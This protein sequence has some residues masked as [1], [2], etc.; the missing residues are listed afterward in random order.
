MVAVLTAIWAVVAIIVTVIVKVTSM[1]GKTLRTICLMIAIAVQG[2]HEVAICNFFG[3]GGFR[4][5]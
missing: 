4:A 1:G 3:L 5:F 2:T